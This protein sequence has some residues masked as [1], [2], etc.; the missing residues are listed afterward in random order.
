MARRQRT[1]VWVVDDATWKAY[2]DDKERLR[3][4]VWHADRALHDAIDWE[5][6]VVPL[7]KELAQ[8]APKG[9]TGVQIVDK[10]LRVYLK[11]GSEEWILIHIEIQSSPDVNFEERLFAYYV[12]IWLRYRR[13]VVSIAILADDNPNWRPSRYEQTI[14]Q[15]QVLFKF[16]TV[17][18]IDLDEQSLID[19]GD[20]ASLILAAFI[21]ATRTKNKADLRYQARI[22]LTKIA[23]DRGYNED[24]VKQ[25]LLFMERAMKL[26]AELEE[27]YEKI[28]KEYTSPS[29]M[30]MLTSIERKAIERG[31][32]RGYRRGERRGEQ[33]GLEKGIAQGLQ[34]AI[35]TSL[36]ELYGH[37]P[38]SV[39]VSLQ[40]IQDADRLTQL[41]TLSLH[42][43]SLE[44]FVHR[45]QETQVQESAGE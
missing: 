3:L 24:E 38:E 4:L 21:R 9:E 35:I 32:R 6:E 26:P 16:P 33:R 29:G 30:T 23:L 43:G 31:L 18:L 12:A 15:F 37:V 2:T 41:L 19:A 13:R 39:I 28:L 11:D 36:K 40:S 7:D 10:L 44:A 34:Q 5:R 42:A 8:I 27:Q 1:F 17:K 20:A 45:L 25:I 22:E 14:G